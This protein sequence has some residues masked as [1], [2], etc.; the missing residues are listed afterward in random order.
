MDGFI[1]V[2]G[3]V[4]QFGDGTPALKLGTNRPLVFVQD[5]L[6]GFSRDDVWA[7]LREA[8]ARWGAVCDW[9][10]TRIMDLSEAGPTDFV[11][12]VTVADLGGRGVLADQMLPYTGGNVLRMRINNRI[13]WRATDG[14]MTGGLIDPIRTLCHEIGHFQGHQHWP[15]GAPAELMEPTVSQTI[16]GPQSTEGK[17]SAGWFG[18]PVV[19]PT[20]G[21]KGRVEFDLDARKVYVPAGWSVEVAR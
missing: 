19:T 13:Q 5:A 16:I 21:G 1:P 17:V 11:N 18:N 3:C 7:W 10:A 12:L 20:P 9:K 4:E 15:V 8:H 6:P 2:C 14:Q